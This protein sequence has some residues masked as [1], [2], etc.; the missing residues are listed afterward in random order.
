MEELYGKYYYQKIIHEIYIFLKNYDCGVYFIPL[1][2]IERNLFQQMK[3]F[4]S[5]QAK[6]L[7]IQIKLKAA[8]MA[9]RFGGI[10]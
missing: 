6:R 3:I 2:F 8:L 9:R 1:F 7:T 4:V 5:T 10:F